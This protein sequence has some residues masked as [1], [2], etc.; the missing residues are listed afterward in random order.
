MKNNFSRAAIVLNPKKDYA[1]LL[2]GIKNH[3]AAHGI[4][5]SEIVLPFSADENFLPDFSHKDSTDLVLSL[6]GDGTLL[7]T[8]RF[9]YGMDVPV[10]GV[11]LGT[12]G[13][14]TEICQEDVFETLDA[15]LAGEYETEQRVMLDVVVKRDGK[16]LDQFFP[17]N[18]VVIARKE[19]SRLIT[20]Q[21]LVN[22][23]YLCTYKADGLIVST[24]TGSTGYSLSAN[25]P[26]LMPKLSNLIIAP[27]CAH[28]LASRPFI[29][30]EEDTVTVVIKGDDISP[31]LSIDVQVGMD[32]NPGDH[33]IIRKAEKKLHL[34][35][36]K[37][38]T[39]FQILREKL[40][41]VDA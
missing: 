34:V 10:F 1:E 18:E 20:L 8:A 36:S 37:Q 4:E 17:L 33:V 3:L 23:E 25:G 39:F 40:G 11:N 5:S 38:R 27:I 9:F 22:N 31:V 15:V 41:W 24:A 28:S 26:I 19:L 7:F 12:F 35:Q 30:S 6:G 29:L 21:T 16:Q 2:D 32:L 13:F 14:L